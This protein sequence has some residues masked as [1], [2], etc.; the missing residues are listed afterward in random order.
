MSRPGLH[1]QIRADVSLF[2]V[3]I[4]FYSSFSWV[5]QRPP[6]PSA[7]ESE[8]SS[9]L[10]APFTQRP[11]ISQVPDEGESITTQPATQ[12]VE[13]PIEPVASWMRDEV[14]RQDDDDDDDDID[15]GEGS[16][17]GLSRSKN[18]PQLEASTDEQASYQQLNLNLHTARATRPRTY[19]P[20]K[21]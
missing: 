4:L 20:R 14:R 21:R 3:H 9:V 5:A 19:K 13:Y 18:I 10:K 2:L 17:S 11:R 7:V 1:R 12:P 15:M 8:F 6:S 16:S